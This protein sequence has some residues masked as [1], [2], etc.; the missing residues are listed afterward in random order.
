MFDPAVTSGSISSTRADACCATFV[1]RRAVLAAGL[2]VIIAG[3]AR[4]LSAES[5]PTDGAQSSI[6]APRHG[7]IAEPPG[8]LEDSSA[9]AVAR[10]I[11]E[12]VPLEEALRDVHGLTQPQ[13]DSL[14]ALEQRY[15]K[16]FESLAGTARSLIDDA[17]ADGL[18][19][20]VAELRALCETV[21]NVRS[22]ELLSA[23]G[24]LTSRAQ[25]SRFDANVAKI[26]CEEA[27][28]VEDVMRRSS[29]NLD[30]SVRT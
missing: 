12:L 18:A 6:V 17:T 16:V 28:L 14:A 19:P 4:T 5:A 22:A 27:L 8:A 30:G 7:D 23:R 25:R 21:W 11:E 15:A 3:G 2:C 10:E 24:I 1:T 26:Q 13:S 29:G 20:N 9:R